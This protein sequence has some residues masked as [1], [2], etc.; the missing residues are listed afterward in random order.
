M[1]FE[2][3]VGDA[4]ARRNIAVCHRTMRSWLWHDIDLSPSGEI[5][6]H[7]G[8]KIRRLAERQR[9]GSIPI[10]GTSIHAPFQTFHG[11]KGAFSCFQRCTVVAQKI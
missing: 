2:T 7:S 1:F 3:S 5:G 9:I 10:S 6:R 8:L 4:S 11:L